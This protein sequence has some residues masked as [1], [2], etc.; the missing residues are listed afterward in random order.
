MIRRDAPSGLIYNRG[1]E[2]ASRKARW[3]AWALICLVAWLIFAATVAAF[4]SRQ[5]WVLGLLAPFRFHYLMLGGVVAIGLLFGVRR[6][7][8]RVGSALLAVLLSVVINLF[9]IAPFWFASLAADSAEPGL[10]VMAFNVFVGNGLLD[11]VATAA[12]V[13]RAIQ[14]PGAALVLVQEVTVHRLTMLGRALPDY[15]LIIGKG[16]PDA[17]GIACFVRRSAEQGEDEI[18]IESARILNITDGYAKA[19]Q[20]EVLCTWRGRPIALLGMHTLSDFHGRGRRYRDVMMR[21]AGAWAK[22][23]KAQGRAVIIMGDFNATPWCAPMIDL[24][25]DANLVDSMLG[26][27]IQ[28]SWPT[29]LPGL[30]RIPIDQ[31]LHSDDLITRSRQVGPDSASSDHLPLTVELQWRK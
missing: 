25:E 6:R 17:F 10:K 11:E 22:L 3:W 30:L 26:F 13:A 21:S 7:F 1:M 16:Q 4:G 9:Q 2:N 29:R 20:V 23:Q 19:P 15:R 12:P 5:W 28:Q 27:G 31:C 18:K 8:R 24:I 14:D